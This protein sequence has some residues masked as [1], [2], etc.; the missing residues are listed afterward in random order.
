MARKHKVEYQRGDNSIENSMRSIKGFASGL[1]VA[2]HMHKKKLPRLK[3]LLKKKQTNK[4]A[5]WSLELMVG[6]K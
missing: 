2:H 6:W 3:E 1:D 4:Q 5:E